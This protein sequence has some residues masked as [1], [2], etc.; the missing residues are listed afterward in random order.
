MTDMTNRQ[1]KGLGKLIAGSVL[2]KIGYIVFDLGN[3]QLQ[4]NEGVTVVKDPPLKWAKI[5]D[6]NFA[7]GPGLFS[8]AELSGTTGYMK[9]HGT[10]CSKSLYQNSLRWVSGF[11]ARASIHQRGEIA[12]QWLIPCMQ[13]KILDGNFLLLVHCCFQS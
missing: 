3:L 8:K 1:F 7:S 6:G 13:A 4:V 2:I 10:T 9:D 5:S 11:K 12:A